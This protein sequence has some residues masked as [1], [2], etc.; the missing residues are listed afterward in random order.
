MTTLRELIEE[1]GYTASSESARGMM[2][3]YCLGVRLR[4]GDST[5]YFFADLIAAAKKTSWDDDL[6]HGVH[7]ANLLSAALD[8]VEEALRNHRTDAMGR[9]TVIYFRGRPAPS[10]DEDEGDAEP[11][12]VEPET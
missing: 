9:G 5:N 6:K 12:S 2:G 1:A 11:D 10:E 4:D 8:E 7:N 3:K